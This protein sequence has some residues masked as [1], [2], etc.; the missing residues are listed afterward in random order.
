MSICA[1]ASQGLIL[2]ILFKLRRSKVN[3]DFK[4]W[5]T[6]AHNLLF[7]WEIRKTE[8]CLRGHYKYL[9]PSCK[10]CRAKIFYFFQLLHGLFC[11]LESNENHGR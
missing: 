1:L 6:F 2:T 8:F 7:L 11:Y 9:C 10:P 3:F 4:I 5:L